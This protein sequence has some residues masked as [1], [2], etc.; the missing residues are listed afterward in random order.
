[1]TLIFLLLTLIIR[2]EQMSGGKPGKDISAEEAIMLAFKH[3]LSNQV[4]LKA[5]PPD[6]TIVYATNEYLKATLKKKSIFGRPIFDVFPPNPENPRSVKHSQEVMDSLLETCKTKKTVVLPV[7]KYDIENPDTGSFEERFW[8]AKHKPV[9]DESGDVIFIIHSVEDITELIKLKESERTARQALGS[10]Q[11]RLLEFFLQAPVAIAIFTSSEFIV[12]LANPNYCKL[13]GRTAEELLYKPFFETVNELKGTD[14][15]ILYEKVLRTGEGNTGRSEYARIIHNGKPRDGYF[16]FVQEPFKEEDGTITGVLTIAIDVTEQVLLRK[17]LEENEKRL[18]VSLEAAKLGVWEIDMETGETVRDSKHDEIFGYDKPEKEWSLEKFLNHI[19]PEDIDIILQKSENAKKGNSIEYECRIITKDGKVKWI[20]V[21]GKSLL[22][23]NGKQKH[24]GVVADITERKKLELQREEYLLLLK[25]YNSE[26]EEV[27]KAKDNFIS[28]ISHDLRNPLSVVVSS[29]DIILNNINEIDKA[30]TENF[31]RVINTSSRRLVKQL[32]NLVELS[33]SKSKKAAFNPI[34]ILLYEVVN[35]AVQMMESL[36]AHK[37]IE[38]KNLVPTDI[39]IFADRYMIQS[40]FQNLI[41]NAIK[42]TP[43]GGHILIKG[44]LDEN[45]MA[46]VRVMDNGVGMPEEIR[47]CLFDES[48]TISTE[49]TEEEKGSGLGLK[50]VKDFV[51]KQGGT[52][53]AESETGK[54]SCFVFTVPQAKET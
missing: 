3:Q 46:E 24:F 30:D 8:S 50:L 25:Q 18:K 39:K 31:V 7:Q 20:E 44:K 6:F 29:S 35:I 40:I 10:Q 53:R 42:F 9:L 22:D 43:E 32:D 13:V 23:Y 37:N 1:M 16:D 15:E 4:L 28:V 11:K 33:K 49:G 51:K 45:G 14:Y 21:K 2:A 41:S 52:I 5:N 27:T 26:L 47:K 34:N 12:E 54:G 17:K 19:H 36:A 38:I 48:S